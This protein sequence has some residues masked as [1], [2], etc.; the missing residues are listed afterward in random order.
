MEKI[1][2]FNDYAGNGNNQE[3]LN[4]VC[5]IVIELCNKFENDTD[6]EDIDSNYYTLKMKFL[7][8]IK[9]LKI[10]D[11]KMNKFKDGIYR[12]LGMDLYK[13]DAYLSNMEK[14]YMLM[15]YV[16]LCKIDDS[17]LDKDVN[18]KLE[19]CNII[20]DYGTDWTQYKA[21]LNFYKLPVIQNKLHEVS[22]VTHIKVR[23]LYYGLLDEYEGIYPSEEW[24]KKAIAYLDGFVVEEKNNKCQNLA[25]L[26][27]ILNEQDFFR[28]LLKENTELYDET[29]IHLSKLLDMKIDE[30][31]IKLLLDTMNDTEVPLV[32]RITFVCVNINII[33][34]KYVGNVID[35][36]FRKGR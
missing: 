16:V 23:D 30:E 12:I 10:D 25:E 1:I 29:L 5:K 7:K 15:N 21:M 24:I 3:E 34:R 13:D 9:E 20:N 33:Y 6:K 2:N 27:K 17:Y 18:E 22:K 11:L 28:E 35:V 14:M 32:T 4:K 36:D 19:E 31:D 26:Y 8:C